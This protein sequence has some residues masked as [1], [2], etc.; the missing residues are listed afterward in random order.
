MFKD[1][2]QSIEACAAYYGDEAEKMK[3]YLIQGQEKALALPN[4]GPI[5]FDK[6]GDIHPDI[7]KTYSKYGFYI[8]ENALGKE[9]LTDLINDLEQMRENFPIEMGATLDGQGRPALGS[10]REGFALQW[11]KPLSD[12]LGGT[13]MLNGRHQ[14]KLFEPQAG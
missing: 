14:V 9:E 7:L 3:Q 6:N 4:R 5:R 8:F 10:D 2:S 12:P 11:A 1:I 13:A